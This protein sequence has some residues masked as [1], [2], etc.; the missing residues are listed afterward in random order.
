MNP[1]APDPLDRED[2]L[3]E[4]RN[5]AAARNK[6]MTGNA[7]VLRVESLYNARDIAQK[8]DILAAL[9]SLIAEDAKK[10]PRLPLGELQLHI[11]RLWAWADLFDGLA[12]DLVRHDQ[13]GTR[14]GIVAGLHD[15]LASAFHETAGKMRSTTVTGEPAAAKRKDFL[16][17]AAD[18]TQF[19][20][21]SAENARNLRNV[22]RPARFSRWTL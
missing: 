1:F 4:F 20:F 7:F 21:R 22:P 12:A 19:G 6:D 16:D 13:T 2:T 5:L 11:E 17:A 18:L 3:R 14:Q 10:T 9:Q 15:G 8:T